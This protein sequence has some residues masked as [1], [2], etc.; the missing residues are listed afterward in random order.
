MAKRHGLS[1]ARAFARKLE[2]AYIE[3]LQR[4]QT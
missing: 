3:M 1:D 4:A 2:A